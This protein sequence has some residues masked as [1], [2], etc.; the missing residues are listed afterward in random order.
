MR[1]GHEAQGLEGRAVVHPQQ[2]H[3]A[4][5]GESV[6][7]GNSAFKSKTHRFCQWVKALAAKP[8]NPGSILWT[9]MMDGENQP[10]QIV[11]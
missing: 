3:K 11:F 8:E 4:G 2:L 1:L 7:P 6:T 5:P 9:P 10:P